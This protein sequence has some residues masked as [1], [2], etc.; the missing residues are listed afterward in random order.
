[1]PVRRSG[2]RD[3]RLVEGQDIEQAG[4]MSFPGEGHNNFLSCNA[5]GGEVLLR[6][7]WW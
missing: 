2:Y 6:R 5:V 4:A 7:S 1:M 3:V